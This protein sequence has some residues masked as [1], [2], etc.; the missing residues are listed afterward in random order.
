MPPTPVA[1]PTPLV[2]PAPVVGGGPHIPATQFTEQQSAP[3]AQT[4]LCATQGVTHFPPVHVPW[5][6]CAVAVQA[7]PCVKQ[8]SGPK[9]QR[10]S[11]LQVLQ[12]PLPLPF[13]Q[14]S[15]VGRQSRFG[16]STWHSPAMHTFEQHWAFFVQGSPT[17][18]HCPPQVPFKHPVEQQSSARVHATPSAKHAERQASIGMPVTGSQ[19]PLKH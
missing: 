18:V 2:P 3:V 12:Q 13:P 9:S 15:P 19:R 6:H 7:T 5:Q 10:P 1:P 8:V 14:S 16:M 17:T 11:L 4:P